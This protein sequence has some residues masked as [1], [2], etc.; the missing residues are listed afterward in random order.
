MT[1]KE[2]QADLLE[3]TLPASAQIVVEQ[4]EGDGTEALAMFEDFLRELLAHIGRSYDLST[5]D[6]LTVV[7]DI[8]KASADL[9]VGV[10]LPEGDSIPP[11]NDDVAVCGASANHVMRDGK[12][13]SHILVRRDIAS[14][15]WTGI[16]K[17]CSPNS[18]PSQLALHTLVH[19][20]AHVEATRK[21]DD[22]FPIILR[23]VEGWDWLDRIRWRA[24][25][26]CWDE[27][28]AC[29][30][31]AMAGK[32]PLDGYVEVFLKALKRSASVRMS[33]MKRCDSDRDWGTMWDAAS[34]LYATLMKYACY[35][36]G[37]MDR[38][39]LEGEQVEVP[40]LREAMDGSW[41]APH[42]ERLGG[43][44]RR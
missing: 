34:S 5:L 42:Y 37:T 33:L 23:P 40:E 12:L 1:T 29:S 39:E 44:C 41:F 38:M 10:E 30:A 28:A 11:T 16:L 3:S 36:L 20:C 25:L 19:E 22:A 2:G 26:A 21:F 6:G 7:N 32:N 27:Y 43:L 17:D 24:I 15:L 9:D 13:K 35:V 4:I 8:A 14:G 31:S 18:E